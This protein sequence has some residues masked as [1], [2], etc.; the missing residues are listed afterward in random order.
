MSNA[1]KAWPQMNLA[2]ATVDTDFENTLARAA[3]AAEEA[4]AHGED[5][6]IDRDLGLE[7]ADG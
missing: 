2:A 7:A 1:R 5:A 4:R 3:D 6:A